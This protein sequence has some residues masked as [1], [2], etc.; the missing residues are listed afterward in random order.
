[1][2]SF[3]RS[4]AGGAAISAL[5]VGS[6]PAQAATEPGFSFTMA[7]L[8][9]GLLRMA[10]P[11]GRMIADIRYGAIEVDGKRGAV[12]LRDVEASGIGEYARCKVTLGQAQISG[13][14]FISGEDMRARIDISDLDVA[15]N[16]FGPQAA[17]IGVVTGGDTI[18]IDRLSIDSRQ[19]MGS[20][21]ATMSFELVSDGIARIEGSADFDYFAVYIPDFFRKLAE[22][23]NPYGAPHP[24]ESFPD[25]MDDLADPALP[26]MEGME[27]MGEMDDMAVPELEPDPT[28]EVGVRGTLRAAHLSVENLGVWERIQP[29]LPPEATDPQ[30]LDAMVTAPAGSEMAAIQQGLAEALRGFIADPSRRVTAEVR[31]ETPLAFDSAEW[32]VPEDGIAHFAPVFANAL[33]TPPLALIADPSAAGDARS[34]GLALARGDGVPQNRRRALGLLLPIK[35]DPEVS[36]ALAGLV[37]EADPAAAYVHAMAAAQQGAAGAPALLDRLEARLP[38]LA[39]LGAQPAANGALPEELFASVVTLRD[40]AL[41]REQ[42]A[43]VARS[44]LLA[45]RLAAPAAAAGDVAAQALIAR[46]DARF[47]GDAAWIAAR[48]GAADAAI[49]DWTGHQL[50]R[51]LSGAAE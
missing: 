35:N 17:M 51:R 48:E 7:D 14:Q 12:T 42:G 40:A 38:T 16:C 44:Y 2:R 24:M 50:G 1:M 22:E 43:G 18:P 28:P 9:G 25:G 39:L 36:M 26:G 5:L 34:L 31:P 41:A 10:V 4:L 11:Y 27:D 47:A 13:L 23:Q 33:P 49:A 20:G 45:W 30:S 29:M 8:A 6:L 21:A 37:A 19:V 3:V 15:T 46:L 32:K